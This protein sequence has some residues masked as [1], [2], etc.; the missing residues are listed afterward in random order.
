MPAV[1][2]LSAKYQVDPIWVISIIW[3][4]SSFTPYAQS[5]AGAYGLMQIM[6]ETKTYL[7][8]LIANKGQRLEKSS[9][10][11]WT[12]FYGKLSTAKIKKIEHD[13][14]NLELGIF[15]LRTLLDRFES[16][17]LATVAYNMGPSWTR[18]MLLNNQPV[19]VKNHY[20]KK[21]K[22]AYQHIKERI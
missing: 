18:R 12:K 17:H 6:P 9:P 10:K 16:H 19:G 1:V 22:T 15:Y 3:T 20:L 21:V 8:K 5:R 14:E 11:F 4:E 13:I 7:K 2:Y